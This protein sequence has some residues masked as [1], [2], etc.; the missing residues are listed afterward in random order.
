MEEIKTEVKEENKPV[1]EKRSDEV[2]MLHLIG[3]F[4]KWFVISVVIGIV[5]GGVA[6]AFDILVEWATEYRKGHDYIIFFLPLAGI[7]IAK[8]YSLAHYIFPAKLFVIIKRHWIG[9]NFHTVI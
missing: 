5:V 8:G 6:A 1:G 3:G 7:V 9:H 4:V 2:S